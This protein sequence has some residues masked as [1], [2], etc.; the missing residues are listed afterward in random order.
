MKAQHRRGE[1]EPRGRDP[2][3]SQIADDHPSSRDA[4]ELRDEGKAAIVVEVM[5]Q[6]RAEH[7]VDAAI[8][9]GKG[10]GI[11]TDGVIHAMARRGHE[12]ERAIDAYRAEGKSTTPGDLTRAPGKIGATHTDVE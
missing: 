10:E 2:A 4:I 7:E 6:L 3:S 11:G 5:E 12:A 9:E 8:G 1:A